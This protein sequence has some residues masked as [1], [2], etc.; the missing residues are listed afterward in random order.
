[1]P[2]PKNVILT[3]YPNGIGMGFVICEN[4]QELITY[5]MLK[6]KPLTKQKHLQILQNYLY[7]YNPSLVIIRDCE[8]ENKN[9]SGR[10]RSLIKS[11]VTEAKTH[12]IKIHYYSR[13]D[14][15]KTFIAFGNT[16]KHG[17]NST[18]VKWYP[19]LKYRLPKKRRN[20]DSEH[21]QSGVFD[22]FS[23]MITHFDEG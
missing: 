20:F 21:Y 4:P 10:T 16:T 3:L 9:I 15:K 14:I 8:T 1:M 19:E 12:D 22:A 7:Y 13:D 6:A 11:L 18:L 5:G 17:I 23:L 2:K